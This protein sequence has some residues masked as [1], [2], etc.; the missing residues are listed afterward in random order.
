MKILKMA[1]YD[2]QNGVRHLMI[3]IKKMYPFIFTYL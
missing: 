1:T 3:L 2:N